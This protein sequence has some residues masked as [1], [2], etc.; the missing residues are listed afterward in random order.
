ML[1]ERLTPGLTQGLLLVAATTLAFGLDYL[2]NLAMGRLLNDPA[3]FSI[4]VALAGASQIMVVASRVVQNVI[5]RY[6]A[7]F[8]ANNTTSRISA[9][10][11]SA[12]RSAWQWG[13]LATLLLGALSWPLANFLQ[14]NQV[15]PVL[16]LAGTAIL[17]TTRPVIG[18]LLQGQ[19]RFAELGLIQLIQATFRLAFGILL[20]LAGLGALGAMLALPLASLMALLFGLW[21]VKEMWGNPAGQPHNI[22][23]PTIFRYSAYT[24]A[25]LIGYAILANMDAILAKRYFTDTM[26]GNYG[27]AVTLAKIIQFF[28][29]A[30]IMILFP[31]AAQRRAQQ[32]DPA[33]ILIPAMLIVSLACGALALLYT[34]FAQPI[35][36]LTL[37][38]AYTLDGPVLGLLGFGMALLSLS[39]VWLNY[40]LSLDN[41]KFVYLIWLA[42]P[43]Q[44]LLMSQYHH[45]LLHFPAIITL[46]G[47]WL[48][49]AGGIIF[50]RTKTSVQPP[51]T[52]H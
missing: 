5:T 29:V 41:T 47:L 43:I 8:R 1:K 51:T 7:D 32:R 17:M 48:T 18:G 23:L 35:V 2:F 33:K 27:A 45:T 19:Q 4:L 36:R 38:P 20:V 24:A 15:G 30:I 28:P 39:N 11:Q 6:I 34:L 40:F 50:W 14:L 3:Q 22:T 49:L 10:F 42:I 52:T 9:F 16:A 12:F 31:K 46:N 13:A 37:G 26:A 44:A 21:R 25:G